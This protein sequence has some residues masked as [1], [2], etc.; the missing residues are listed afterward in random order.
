MLILID[1]YTG[2]IKVGKMTFLC[3]GNIR[4]DSLFSNTGKREEV[5]LKSPKVYKEDKNDR[6]FER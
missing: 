2:V 1:D 6:E 5:S 4:T 3:R